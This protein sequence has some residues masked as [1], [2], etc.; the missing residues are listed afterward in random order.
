MAD[1]KVNDDVVGGE[2][3]VESVEVL[4]AREERVMAPQALR[5][6]GKGATP[7]V[8]Q[9]EEAVGGGSEDGSVTR[10]AAGEQGSAADEDDSLCAICLHTPALEDIAIVKGCDHTYC[11][12]CILTWALHKEDAGW[13]PQCRIPFSRLITYRSLDGSLYD[14]PQEESVCLLKRACWFQEHL[15]VIEKGKSPLVGADAAPLLYSQHDEWDDYS[16][17]YDEYDEDQEVEDYY[18]SSAAGRARVIVGNRRW[19]DGGYVAS[20]RRAARPVVPNNKTPG[21]G[22]S[23]G[24]GS[25]SIPIPAG[26]VH[27]SASHKQLS[28][29]PASVGASPGVSSGSGGKASAVPARAQGSGGGAKGRRARRNARRAVYDEDDDN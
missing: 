12:K 13:C 8:T 5:I 27:H 11:V 29:S 19:G 7:A 23:A 17:Y 24:N 16:R 10:S 28:G 15:R 21:K 3:G 1:D 9:E 2:L 22:K 6:E 26:G 25:S 4:R 14:Y 20:G 18:F